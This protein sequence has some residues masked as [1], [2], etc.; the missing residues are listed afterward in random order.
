MTRRLGDI[1]EPQKPSKKHSPTENM[2][3][4]EVVD[5]IWAGIGG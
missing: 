4:E 2:T 5:K 1:L 3:T